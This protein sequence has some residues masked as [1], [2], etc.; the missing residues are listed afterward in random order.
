MS[1]ILLSP[2]LDC[3]SVADCSL[4]DADLPALNECF[5]L[6]GRSNLDTM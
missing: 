1:F 5:D 4:T 6:I 2:R 3:R